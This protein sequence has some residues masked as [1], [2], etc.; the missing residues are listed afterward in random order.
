[1]TVRNVD[2]FQITDMA[3]ADGA[4][5]MMMVEVVIN[6]RPPRET[7]AIEMTRVS[8]IAPN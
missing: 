4:T 7:V 6:Y 1:M 3:V 8:W 5:E 2:P